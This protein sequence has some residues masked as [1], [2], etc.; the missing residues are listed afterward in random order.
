MN[1]TIKRVEV[2]RSEYTS[3]DNYSG[4][5]GKLIM[6]LRTLSYIHIGSGMFRVDVDMDMVKR[7]RKLLRTRGFEYALGREMERAVSLEYFKFIK[8]GDKVVVPASTIKGLLRSRLEL[9][10]KGTSG[11]VSSCFSRASRPLG[12]IPPKGSHG[13]RHARIWGDVLFEDRGYPCNPTRSKLVCKVCDI[14]GAPGLISRVFIGNFYAEGDIVER[15]DL[16]YGEKL[17]VVRSNIVFKG[18]IVFHALKLDEIGLLF[19]AL[20]ADRNG[21]FVPL[22][23]GKHKYSNKDFGK[24]KFEVI[25]VLIYEY[26]KQSI[27]KGIEH[28]VYE[29]SPNFVRIKSPK[30]LIVQAISE[31]CRKYPDIADSIGFSEA[32]VR[33]RKI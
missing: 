1:V 33:D 12:I 25:D 23:I 16:P 22:L 13:W 6:N 14:F 20:G 26:G 8:Y 17:E 2:R 30:D 24:I 4:L 21:D 3:R 28:E 32:I 31:A 5:T 18:E 11:S 27:P 15:K 7:F 10:F 29:R 9:L 19:I